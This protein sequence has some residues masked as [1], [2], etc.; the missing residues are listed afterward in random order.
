VC[1]PGFGKLSFARCLA[2]V[3]LNTCPR[4]RN[5]D[6]IL[7]TTAFGR[8]TRVSYEGRTTNTRDSPRYIRRL[9]VYDFTDLAIR[10]SRT[11]HVLKYALQDSLQ[12]KQE[13][14]A[15]ARL[16]LTSAPMLE[17][18]AASSACQRVECVQTRHLILR[19][20]RHVCTV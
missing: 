18:M 11:R 12:F 6:A 17:G 16:G 20:Q 2:A 8:P 1:N 3:G 9:V 10:H 4:W 13:G 7:G 14:G 15:V 5:A 19:L